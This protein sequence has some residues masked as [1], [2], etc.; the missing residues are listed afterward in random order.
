MK[1]GNSMFSFSNN[2]KLEYYQLFIIVFIKFNQFISKERDE[3]FDK[4]N[5]NEIN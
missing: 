1:K 5:L 4:N 3:I 2:M